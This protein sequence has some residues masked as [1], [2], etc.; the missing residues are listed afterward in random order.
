M[1][2]SSFPLAC[3]RSPQLGDRRGLGTHRMLV[4]MCVQSLT[5]LQTEETNTFELLWGF[6][7][8]VPKKSSAVLA[9]EFLRLRRPNEGILLAFH[10][11]YHP[12]WSRSRPWFPP[13]RGNVE[14]RSLYMTKI[15]K[16]SRSPGGVLQIVSTGLKENQIYL[17]FPNRN[18]TGST[19]GSRFIRS[20]ALQSAW[21]RRREKE[22]GA[23]HSSAKGPHSAPRPHRVA[24]QVAGV[25]GWHSYKEATQ[26]S[27]LMR[28]RGTDVLI[29]SLGS[30][31]LLS[32]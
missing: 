3:S 25:G 23:G 5:S 28:S 15:N 32:A 29:S 2:V 21:R 19:K 14:S 30:L 24:L 8:D 31:M 22:R 11:V 13:W 12:L 1:K 6:A 7:A 26:R 20:S 16:W 10:F 27:H 4:N 18:G 9:S 17:L